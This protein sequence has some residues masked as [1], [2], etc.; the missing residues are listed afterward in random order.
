MK[1]LIGILVA[2]LIIV[3]IVYGFTYLGNKFSDKADDTIETT[4]DE[5]E[6]YR[7]KIDRINEQNERRNDQMENMIEMEK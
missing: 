6:N 4:S 2:T 1:K 7:D 3:G 5:V